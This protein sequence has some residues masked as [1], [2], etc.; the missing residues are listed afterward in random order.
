[1]SNAAADGSAEQPTDHSI[2]HPAAAVAHR[3]WLVDSS[4]YVFRAWQGVAAEID[5]SGRESQSVRGYAAWLAGLLHHARPRLC[6][7]TFDSHDGQ[8]RRRQLSAAYKA[9]RK[10]MSPTLFEQ[11]ERC[12]GVARAFGVPVHTGGDLEADDLI[13]HFASLAHAADHPVTIVSGDKDLAQYLHGDDA[14]WDVGRRDALDV[15]G[16][17]RRFGVRPAQIPD[18]LAL[19]GDASDGIQG[20]PGVGEATAA[21][22]LKRFGDLDGLF[23][24]PWSVANMGF[25]GAPHVAALLPEWESRVRASR[26]LTGRLEAPSLPDSLTALATRA[27]P[28]EDIVDDL[29]ALGI[30]IEDATRHARRVATLAP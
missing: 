29:T 1:V 5:A 7:C 15:R 13:G 3:V 23:A 18:W 21:R 27:R 28:V 8:G 24:E 9:G 22:L 17:T 4:L 2:D 12:R 26:V 14:W 6:A 19:A 30:D 16:V 25:R 10:P 11:M 20:I